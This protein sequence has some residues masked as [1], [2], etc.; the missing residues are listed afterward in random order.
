[1]VTVFYILKDSAKFTGK[2]WR[3]TYYNTKSI[4][5]PWDVACYAWGECSMLLFTM[6]WLTYVW[7]IMCVYGLEQFDAPHHCRRGCIICI[8]EAHSN[9]NLLNLRPDAYAGWIA[10]LRVR[11]QFTPSGFATESKGPFALYC[12]LATLCKRPQQDSIWQSWE[13][14]MLVHCWVGCNVC[15]WFSPIVCCNTCSSVPCTWYCI[16]HTGVSL[17]CA[18]IESPVVCSRLPVRDSSKHLSLLIIRG[19]KLYHCQL[20]NGLHCNWFDRRGYRG[21]PDPIIQ[22]SAGTYATSR[23]ASLFLSLMR[24][25]PHGSVASRGGEK[26]CWCKVLKGRATTCR[27]DRMEF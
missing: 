27:L 26:V 24:C 20:D 23:Y 11:L 2:G 1:M 14:L 4:L 22:S 12:K 9:V 3:D 18:W 8:C 6:N 17:E 10:S 16:H 7:G 21:K 13:M 19:P 15:I 25:M 5:M